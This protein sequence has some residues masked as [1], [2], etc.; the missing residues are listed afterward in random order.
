MI[1]TDDGIQIDRI[2]DKFGAPGPCFPNEFRW[3]A[4]PATETKFRGNSVNVSQT[5]HWQILVSEAS[6]VRWIA[7]G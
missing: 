6:S 5:S 7:L 4:R 1:S 3:I 2:P